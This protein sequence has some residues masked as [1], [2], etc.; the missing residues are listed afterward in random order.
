DEAEPLLIK[1]YEGMKARE[2]T[3][4]P[5]AATRILEALDRL[6]ELYTATNKPD[7][8]KKYQQL[9]ANYPTPKEVAPM[10]KEKK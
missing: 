1:G 5:S 4:P 10:P 7:E 9:R 6:V 3:I 8:L 2:K